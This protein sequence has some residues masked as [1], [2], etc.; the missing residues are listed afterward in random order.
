MVAPKEKALACADCHKEGGR[1]GGVPG[2]WLPGQDR[3]PLL[4]RIGFGLAGFT[5]VGVLGHAA[6]RFAVRKKRKAK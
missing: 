1:L 6:L 2:V 3:H 5:F 4:E